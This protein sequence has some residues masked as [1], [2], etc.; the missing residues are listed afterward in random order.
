[1]HDIPSDPAVGLTL[2]YRMAM[3]FA[4]YFSYNDTQTPVLDQNW[5]N[6]NSWSINWHYLW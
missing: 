5:R 1:M 4:W 2:I 6:G 3:N